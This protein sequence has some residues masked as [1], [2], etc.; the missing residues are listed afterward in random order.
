MNLLRL[1]IIIVILL[2]LHSCNS[3]TIFISSSTMEKNEWHYSNIITYEFDITD[4]INSNNISLFMRTDL[5]YSYRNIYLIISL[6]NDNLTILTD[7]VQYTIADQYGRWTGDGIGDIKSNYLRLNDVVAFP[8]KGIYYFSI[9]H[10]MRDVS[11]RGVRRVGL[12]I[13]K[14]K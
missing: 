6:F 5:D 14:N 7:T 12:E 4:T 8:G 10:G 13:K 2:T 9:K 3:D 11:L 1:Q